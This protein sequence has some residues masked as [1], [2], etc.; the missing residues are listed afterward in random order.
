MDGLQGTFQVSIRRAC[1]VLQFQK[2]SYFYRSR[3]L[4]QAALTKRI[5]EIAETR[6]RYGY[7]RIHVLLPREGWAVNHKRVYRLYGEEGLPIRNK[8]PKR[9]VAAKVGSDRKP[10]VAPNEVWAMDFMSDQLFDGRPF[11]ILTVVE[12]YARVACDRAASELPGLSGRR[13]AR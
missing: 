2:S 8:R 3:R 10:P 1:H 7:R 9:K 13:G 4:S 11:R 6:V 12:P 5:R